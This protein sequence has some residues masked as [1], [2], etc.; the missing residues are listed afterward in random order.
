M[1]MSMYYVV[2]ITCVYVHV[3]VA[4]YS[5]YVHVHVHVHMYALG[6]NGRRRTGILGYCII[7]ASEGGK[8]GGTGSCTRVM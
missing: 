3:Y 7:L 8:E 4:I 6:C 1:Y 5:I 2:F